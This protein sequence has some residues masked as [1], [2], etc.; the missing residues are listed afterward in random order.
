VSYHPAIGDIREQLPRVAIIAA[1]LVAAVTLIGLDTRRAELP[2]ERWYHLSRQQ[3]MQADL[4]YR[5]GDA[6]ARVAESAS[7]TLTDDA[8]M[9]QE[10]AIAI[11]ERRTLSGRP[12]HGAAYRLGVIY[13]HRGYGEQAADM[14]TLA[15]SLDEASSSYYHALAEVYSQPDLPPDKLRDKVG[16]IGGREGWLVDMVLADCYGRLE[17]DASLAAVRARQQARATRFLAGFGAVG[18][19]G[20]ALLVTGLV[21]LVILAVRRGLSLPRA[22]AR[23]PFMVPWTIIDIAEAIA[24]MLFALV[25]GGL[26][27]PQAIGST[28][29]SDGRPELRALAVALQY[30][31]VAGV[32]I[33]VIVHR[34]RARSSRPLRTLGMRFR[35]VAR[36]VG[37]GLAG[38]AVFVTAIVAVAAIIGALFGGGL[39]LAQTTEEIVGGAKSPGE[40]VLYLVLVSV[41]APIAEETIFRGYLYGGLRRFLPAR[42]AIV[43]GGVLFA[44]VHLNADAFLV[45]G[46]IGAM[47]CYLYEHTRS[48]LPGIVAHSLH[49]GL[50]LAV[51]LLQSL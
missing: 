33:A 10:R 36:L 21:T 23:L 12:G 41:I 9:L 29:A 2:S 18:G 22:E 7:V 25:L 13:G 39:P 8:E 51:M 1:L 28:L 47:L 40:I 27:T 46:L 4:I 6:A 24:V 14:L 11:W 30:I 32:T 17:D 20:A 37:I 31:L 44:A 49:N 15:A 19:L 42:H 50:V 35:G 45:I 38:Y 5:L 16:V 48:L 26:V 3:T 34:V 43:I